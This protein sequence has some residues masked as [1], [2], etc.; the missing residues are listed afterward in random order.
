M[1]K[2]HK[3][4]APLSSSSPPKPID[5]FQLHRSNSFQIVPVSDVTKEA[6]IISS[7]SEKTDGLVVTKK[8]AGSLINRSK[9]RTYIPKLGEREKMRCSI[10]MK[11]FSSNDF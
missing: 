5:K 1:S 7:R 6:S 10:D 8:K 11:L 3:K 4:S 2:S 9:H